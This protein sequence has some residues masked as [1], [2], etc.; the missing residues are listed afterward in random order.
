MGIPSSKNC[1]KESVPFIADRFAHVFA[2][3]FLAEA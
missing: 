1:V 3:L 2:D